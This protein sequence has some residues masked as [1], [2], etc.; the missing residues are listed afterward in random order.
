MKPNAILW[1]SLLGAA[2]VHGNLEVGEVALKQLLELGPE[3]SGNFVLL[4]NL[5]SS[6]DRWEDV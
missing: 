2:R 6:I 4:S 1:R 3:T 5:Y